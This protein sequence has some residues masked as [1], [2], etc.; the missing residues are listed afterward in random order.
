MTHIREL[1]RS[2]SGQTIDGALFGLEG[3]LV[4]PFFSPP[5]AVTAYRSPDGQTELDALAVAADGLRWAVEIKWRSR[6]AG[7]KELVALCSKAQA[8]GARAWCISRSG[9]TP[10]ARAYAAAHGV[11]LSTRSDLDQIARILGQY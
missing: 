2:F 11:L 3:I 4:L 8:V 7:D 6:A 1:L 9:F 5:G 10:A